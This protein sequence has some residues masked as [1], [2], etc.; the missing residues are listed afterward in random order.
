MV[1]DRHAHIQIES[2]FDFNQ[3][4]SQM[5]VHISLNI[6]IIHLHLFN[7]LWGH[8]TLHFFAK[9]IMKFFFSSL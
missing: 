3:N 1:I 2:F 6:D 7:L 9:F 4:T 5:V 8:W